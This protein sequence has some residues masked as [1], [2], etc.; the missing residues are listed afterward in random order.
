M[1]NKKEA[2][3]FGDKFIKGELASKQNI[4]LLIS[5]LKERA[6]M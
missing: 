4:G 1:G 2:A 6:L 5:V 3:S